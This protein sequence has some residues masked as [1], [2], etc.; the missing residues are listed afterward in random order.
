MKMLLALDPFGSSEK[1]LIEALKQAKLQGAELVILVVAETFLDIEHSFTGLAGASEELFDQVKAKA[2]KVR[3]AAI[4]QGV[5]PKMLTETGP[6]PAQNI[7][8]CAANEKVDLIVM[9]SREKKGLDRFLLGSVAS[10]IVAHAPCSVLV[11]R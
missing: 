5:T 9:G 3:L 2:E 8:D 6:S 1:A 11:V 7:L 10:K 4:G